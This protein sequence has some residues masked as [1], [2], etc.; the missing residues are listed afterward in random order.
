MLDS[1]GD[2]DSDTKGDK[3]V[4]GQRVLPMADDSK[5]PEGLTHKGGNSAGVESYSDPSVTAFH[6]DNTV[7]PASWLKGRHLDRR[8][9][10][11]G[12][13]LSSEVNNRWDTCVY[14]VNLLH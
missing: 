4:P 9:S 5:I 2:A 1:C 11:D 8:H 7:E 13:P 10:W 6:I 3:A 12:S 14:T